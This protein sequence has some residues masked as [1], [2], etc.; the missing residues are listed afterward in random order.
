MHLR[1][2]L[3]FGPSE[4]YSMLDGHSLALPHDAPKS[5]WLGHAGQNDCFHL[6]IDVR[7]DRV[8]VMRT[9]Q[10]LD[11]SFPTGT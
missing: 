6:H 3:G 7:A 4:P 9:Q 5:R 1:R 11:I 2:V 8:F 10:R